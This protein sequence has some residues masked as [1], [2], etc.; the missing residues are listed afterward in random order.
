MKSL[1]PPLIIH[2]VKVDKLALRLE[3]IL[4][5]QSQDSRFSSFEDLSKPEPEIID[6]T[7]DSEDEGVP[8][9]NQ[10]DERSWSVV[11]KRGKRNGKV[12]A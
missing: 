1:F 6:L 12:K 7:G 5:N 8:N 11:V 3:Q 4:Q 10:E 9:D 2:Q